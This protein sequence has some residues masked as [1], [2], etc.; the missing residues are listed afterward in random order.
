MNIEITIPKE[1]E[2][3]FT[4]D[5][6]EE[7]FNRIITDL[8]CEETRTLV[9]NYELETLNMLKNAIIKAKTIK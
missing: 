9:G 3:E 7:S 4:K 8:N 2:K 5:K 6:F 1:W